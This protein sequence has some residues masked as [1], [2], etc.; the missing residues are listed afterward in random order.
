MTILLLGAN[1]QVGWEL[2][3]TLSPLGP[4]RALERAEADLADHDA[5]VRVVR[6][7]APSLIVNA[8]AYTAVD[9]AEEEEAQARAVNG[10]A[11]GIL[12][13][14]AKRLGIA[15]VHYSTDYVFDG[16]GNRPA[17]EDDPVAPQNAYGRTK[18]EGEQA[19]TGSGCTHLIFRTS[20]VYSLRGRNFLLTV[21]RLAGELEEL[22]IV[23]DQV[24]APTWA[25]GIAEATA[26]VLASCGTVENADALAGR[27]GLYH[28]AASGVTSWHGFAEA[29]VGWMRA[30]GQPVKSRAVLPIR[31]T[32]YPTPAKRPAY[33]ALDCSKLQDVFGISLP[34]WCEQLS[35]CVED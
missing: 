19:I 22:R 35:L 3:R 30:T 32:D 7:M 24:G 20:W 14:E 31:T 16:A 26:L 6:E 10:Q 11:P 15:L 21:K 25:R 2:Q 28:L 23:V 1:G 27:G 17:R 13:E 8:A 34:D 29:I 4:V 12:A 5:L 9:K 33:S 18:L